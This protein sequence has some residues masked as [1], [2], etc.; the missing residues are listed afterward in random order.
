MVEAQRPGGV[1]DVPVGRMPALLLARQR[2]GAPSLRGT[3]P[4]RRQ[5]AQAAPARPCTSVRAL[6]AAWH[7]CRGRPP[8]PGR[9]RPPLPSWPSDSPAVCRAHQ[10]GQDW[11]AGMLLSTL[12]D[13]C[14]SSRSPSWPSGSRAWTH[15]SLAGAE[16]RRHNPASVS[17]LELA[18][19]ACHHWRSSMLDPRP[20]SED[21]AMPAGPCASS[22]EESGRDVTLHSLGIL[23]MSCSLP[24]HRRR[25]VSTSRPV[26]TCT[27]RH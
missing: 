15:V 18:P 16:A 21:A 6:A 27:H 4:W 19:D 11:S 5:G 2:E 9:R 26:C 7:T 14:K 23:Y 10:L 17:W 22:I 13:R 12:G 3:R 20:S 1:G 24:M 8:L 25:R